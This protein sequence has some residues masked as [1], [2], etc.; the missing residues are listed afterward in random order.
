MFAPATSS[1]ASAAPSG[2]RATTSA[3][4]RIIRFLHLPTAKSRSA[5]A[6]LDASTSTSCRLPERKHRSGQKGTA[7]TRGRPGRDLKKDRDQKGEEGS[8]LS[9]LLSF[10]KGQILLPKLSRT[11]CSGRAKEKDDV[12]ENA[13]TVAEAG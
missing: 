4:A 10:L 12:R 5:T 1:C 9:S 2:T 7:P 11:A 3:W 13:T 6:S 8:P